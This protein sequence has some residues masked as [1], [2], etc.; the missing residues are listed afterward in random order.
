MRFIVKY[1]DNLTGGIILF[2]A[3]MIIGI[4]ELYFLKKAYQANTVVGQGIKHEQAQRDSS[5]RVCKQFG[6]TWRGT[7]CYRPKRT[8]PRSIRKCA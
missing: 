8:L 4:V 2:G 6:G 5:I 3:A 7:C 1:P